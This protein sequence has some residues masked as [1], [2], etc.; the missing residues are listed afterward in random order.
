MLAPDSYLATLTYEDFKKLGIKYYYSSQKCSD[1][2]IDEFNLES[3]YS[4][5]ENSQYIY[6]INY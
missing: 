1:E 5:D 4:N 6:L 2:I 3:K